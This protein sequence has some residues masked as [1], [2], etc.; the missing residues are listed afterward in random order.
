MIST[1]INLDC[2][3]FCA[4]PIFGFEQPSYTFDESVGTGVLAVVLDSESGQLGQD[5]VFTFSTKD[6]SAIGECYL[7]LNAHKR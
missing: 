4:V 2:S 1:N 3:D 5:L 6:G 7:L